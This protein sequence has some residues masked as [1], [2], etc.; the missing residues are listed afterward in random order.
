VEAK[1]LTLEITEAAI[2]ADAV[3]LASAVE[4]LRDLGI[5][6]SVDDFGTGYSTLSYLRDLPVHELKLDRSFV[7]GIES[8]PKDQ[9]IVKATLALARFARLRVVAEGVETRSDLQY[10]RLLEVDVV[11]G[12]YISRPQAPDVFAKMVGRGQLRERL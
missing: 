6:I 1:W 2:M 7:T 11:Q 12:Y 10:L 4:S 3:G 8:R 5:T 9:T